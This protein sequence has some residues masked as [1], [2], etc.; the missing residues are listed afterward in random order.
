MKV[1]F[2]KTEVPMCHDTTSSINV[3]RVRYGSFTFSGVQLCNFA[4]HFLPK[5][6]NCQFYRWNVY[7]EGRQHTEKLSSVR[8][9]SW[10]AECSSE[11][12][13]LRHSTCSSAAT[14][15]FTSWSTWRQAKPL[16]FLTTII[17]VVF[18]NN[19]N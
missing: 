18:M 9:Q 8:T 4:S 14:V 15:W 16:H 3:S 5:S 1:L 11:A 13:V 7:L 10:M 2:F 6:K 17:T 12:S 19:I